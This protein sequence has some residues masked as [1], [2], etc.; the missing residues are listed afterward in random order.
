M[1]AFFA[2][3]EQLDHPELRGKP[4]LIGSAR[5]RG[6]VATASYEARPFGCRS[7]Q[8]MAVALRLCPH[9][10]VVPVRMG[11]YSEVSDRVFEIIESFSPVV[12]PLSI[13]EAFLDVTGSQRLL[14]NPVEI[15]KKLKARI[16]SELHITASV[17]V[18]HNKFLAKLASD[19]D[20]PD[21]LTVIGTDDVDRVL[22]PLPISKLWGVGPKTAARLEGY[23][24][25]TFGDVR[26]YTPERLTRL[27]GVDGEH[28]HRL[29][30]GL[31]DRDV[32]PDSAAK[33]IGQEETFET[34][35]HDPEEIRS[36]LLGQ[37]EHVGARLRRHKLRASGV[38]LKIRYGA[39][40]TITRS[41]TLS[42]PTDATSELISAA[43]SIY[44]AWVKTSFQP[45][46]LIGMTATRLSGEGGQMDLFTDPGRE[47]LRKLDTALDRINARFGKQSIRRGN[48][49]T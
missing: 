45:V 49:S 32:T 2:A 37:V 22:P 47:R 11:R 6:V 25:H 7:A 4:I 43:Q 8:P 24:I 40:K 10:I 3:V 39:F 1:D 14:G 41:A 17:G 31:D 19:M 48:S 23:G 29:A 44:G 36:V 27:C 20:K 9:A 16:K 18:S 12:E 13:D 33:S 35:V 21:G 28:L 5:A 30:H 42:A 38:T 26:R 46:R 34:D 15:A